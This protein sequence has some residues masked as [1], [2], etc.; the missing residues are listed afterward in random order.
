MGILSGHENLPMGSNLG[1]IAPEDLWLE[2]RTDTP[3]MNNTVPGK[4]TP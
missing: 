4:P 1:G 2:N 3:D